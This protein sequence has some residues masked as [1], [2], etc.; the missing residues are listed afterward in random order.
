MGVQ[1]GFEEDGNSHTVNDKNLYLSIYEVILNKTE[2]CIYHV[3]NLISKHLTLMPMGTREIQN[4]YQEEHSKS[5]TSCS[6]GIFRKG[7][8][9][10]DNFI[11]CEGSLYNVG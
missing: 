10:E 9:I 1:S 11:H 8:T 7:D 2:I 4:H 6:L 3:N 5:I